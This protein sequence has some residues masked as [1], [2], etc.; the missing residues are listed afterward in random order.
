MPTYTAA[1]AVTVTFAPA[2]TAPGVLAVGCA[3]RMTLSGSPG[4]LR[5]PTYID[6]TTGERTP[7]TVNEKHRARKMSQSEKGRTY[8][9]QYLIQG[10]LDP[11]ACDDLGPQIGDSLEG[12]PGLLCTDRQL[13]TYGA[14]G[15]DG[16]VVLLDVDYAEP[17]SDSQSTDSDGT[18]AYEFGAE[19]EHIDTARAQQTY[20][21]ALREGEANLI[22]FDGEEV[23]GVD[24]LSP[25]ID[26]TEEHIY[27]E[28]EFSP[29]VRQFVRDHIGKVN[30][31]PFREWAAGEVLFASASAS[32]Q[33]RVWRVTFKFRVRRNIV[34]QEFDLVNDAGGITTEKVSKQGWQ[35]LWVKIERK[36]LANKTD[37]RTA[38]VSVHV[39]T[40]YEAV[41]FS[42]LGI[43]TAPLI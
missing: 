8:Q 23:G 20:G 41:T 2:L 27:T 7:V 5:V 14:G 17:E 39:A 25:I 34:D 38:P 12:A 6:P 29:G 24:I 31:Q 26:V 1:A 36:S 18:F 35:Y 21:K 28:A 22:N 13:T 16:D 33:A 19:S 11:T 10:T 42:T 43:G 4:A 32:K 15:G 37:L 3:V 40:V 30:A 9:T